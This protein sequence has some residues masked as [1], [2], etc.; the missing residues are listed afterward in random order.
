M[1]IMLVIGWLGR[2]VG[3]VDDGL[4]SIIVIL[5]SFVRF[6]SARQR[7]MLITRADDHVRT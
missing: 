1:V 7:Q 3:G 5:R 4:M 6:I 2:A